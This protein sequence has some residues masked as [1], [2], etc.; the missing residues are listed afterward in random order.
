M[1][2]RSEEEQR[3]PQKPTAT[4]D[5]DAKFPIGQVTT[6]GEEQPPLEYRHGF[7][8]TGRIAI[9]KFSEP[10]AFNSVMAYTFPMSAWLHDG[11]DHNGELAQ[12]SET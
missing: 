3:E 5:A 9:C 11:N 4:D 12:P 10:I 6:L 1:D 7:A 8:D 2:S